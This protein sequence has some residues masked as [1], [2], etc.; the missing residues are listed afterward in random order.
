[1]NQRVI[2]VRKQEKN[3][4]LL[5]I[6]LNRPIESWIYGRSKIPE[7][8]EVTKWWKKSKKQRIT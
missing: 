5:L 4:Y 8:E 1:V 6:Y 7:N 2:D 3:A